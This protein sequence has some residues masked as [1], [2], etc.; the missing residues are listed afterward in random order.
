M[1]IIFPDLQYGTVLYYKI[2]YTHNI[3]YVHKE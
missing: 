3:Y 2:N 1:I